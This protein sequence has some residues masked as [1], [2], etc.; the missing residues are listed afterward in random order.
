MRAARKRKKKKID[1]KSA[2][3]IISRPQKRGGKNVA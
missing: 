2:S 3:E 1:P